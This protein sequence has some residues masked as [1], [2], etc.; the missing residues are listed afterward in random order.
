MK[1]FIFFFL[2]KYSIDILGLYKAESIEKLK[3]S[4][5]DERILKNINTIEKYIH[6]FVD[7]AKDYGIKRLS[8]GKKINLTVEKLDLINYLHS[9][10]YD[11]LIKNGVEI[12]SKELILVTLYDDFNL[13]IFS[14]ILNIKNITLNDLERFIHK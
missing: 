10:L 7:T 11:I 13:P 12:N 14:G 1:N 6:F 2:I 5:S 9:F 8:T 3:I 4:K